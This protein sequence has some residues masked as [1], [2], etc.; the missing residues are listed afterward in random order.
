MGSVIVGVIGTL[1]GVLVGGAIQQLQAKRNRTWQ[2]EDSL[3]NAKRHVYAEYLRAISASYAQAISGDRRRSE[4]AN[5]L[6]ATAEIEILS[7]A[8]VGGPVR[9]LVDIIIDVHSRIADGTVAADAVVPDVDRRRRE[10]IDLFRSDLGLQ[11]SLSNGT[12]AQAVDS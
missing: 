2:R 6:A 12:L 5:L 10:V 8:E 4:D 1:L 7:G 11:S 9:D 3:A